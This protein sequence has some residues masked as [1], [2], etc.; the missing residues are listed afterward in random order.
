MAAHSRIVE[1]TG[2]TDTP[3]MPENIDPL[4]ATH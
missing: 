2:L 3:R 4:C 1:N